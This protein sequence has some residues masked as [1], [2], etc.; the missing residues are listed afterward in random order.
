[1]MNSISSSMFV[2]FYGF[3]GFGYGIRLSFATA[4][5]FLVTFASPETILLQSAVHVLISENLS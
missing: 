3:S 5:E 2:H 4:I 1:M